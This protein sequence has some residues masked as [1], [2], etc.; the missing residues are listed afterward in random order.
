MWVWAILSMPL[1]IRPLDGLGLKGVPWLDVG[2]VG[3]HITKFSPMIL[4][5][6]MLLQLHLYQH[7][8]MYNTSASSSG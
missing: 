3:G 4:L 5:I 6:I 2:L 8:L 7:L 1:V